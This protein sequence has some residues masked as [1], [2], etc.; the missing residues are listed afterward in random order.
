MHERFKQQALLTFSEQVPDQ[1]ISPCGNENFQVLQVRLV[2]L[3][4]TLMF[5]KQEKCFVE[6]NLNWDSVS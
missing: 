5:C 2:V 1:T 4:G 3:A 6:M